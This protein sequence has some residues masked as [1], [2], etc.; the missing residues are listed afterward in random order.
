M[1]LATVQQD[2]REAIGAVI[3]D[4]DK[5]AKI[6]AEHGVVRCDDVERLPDG[7]DGFWIMNPSQIVHHVTG[8]KDAEPMTA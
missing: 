5:A 3:D 1:K 6:L 7:F 4:A 8:S 2:G